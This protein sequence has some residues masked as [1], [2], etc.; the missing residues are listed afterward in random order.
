MKKIEPHKLFRAL[1]TGSVG[2]L[3]LTFLTALT[4]LVGVGS[5]GVSQPPPI[6][7]QAAKGEWDFRLL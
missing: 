1:R 4:L 3:P 7:E 2:K 5:V 6:Q